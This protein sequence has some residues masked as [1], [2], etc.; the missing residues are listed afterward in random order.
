M[1][2]LYLASA[3]VFPSG[4]FANPTLTT[5]ALAIRVADDIKRKHQTRI[6]ARAMAFA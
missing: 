6:K 3:S 5:V 4:G 1:G 2:N